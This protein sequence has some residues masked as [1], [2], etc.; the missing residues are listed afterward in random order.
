SGGAGLGAGGSAPADG[1]ESRIRA[2]PQR[3][4]ARSLESGPLGLGNG[5]RDGVLRVPNSTDGAPLPLLVFLHGATQSGAGMVRRIGPAAD[6]AGVAV[7]APDSLGT[8]WDAIRGE[9][10]DDVAFL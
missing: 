4:V 7:L 3:G 8:T 10:G 2:R 6:A 5:D 9:F 1:R